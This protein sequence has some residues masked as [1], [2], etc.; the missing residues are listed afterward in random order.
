MEEPDNKQSGMSALFEA[1]IS[2]H[3][4]FITLLSAGF[5]EYQALVIV[6]QV[7]RPQT[8]L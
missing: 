5:T 1:A 2:L 7:M 6:S 8:N 4:M 3:E